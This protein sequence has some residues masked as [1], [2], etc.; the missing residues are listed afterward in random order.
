MDSDVDT[1]VEAAEA[2]ADRDELD[3]WVREFL[4]TPGSDNADL[5]DLFDGTKTHWFGPVVLPFD[6]LN[7]LAGP[8]HQ[9]TLD[10]LDE[11]DLETVEGMCE[12]IRDGWEPPPVIVTCRGGQLVVEDGNHR[13]EGLRRAGWSEYWSV[14]GFDSADERDRFVAALDA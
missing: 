10:R 7:R 5:A 14:I 11:D 8:P 3:V 13:I 4:A 9:P 12:S 6:D 1:T 2:A